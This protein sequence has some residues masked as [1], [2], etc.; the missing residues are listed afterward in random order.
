MLQVNTQ[1][2]TPVVEYPDSD[3]LPLSDNSKQFRW[4]TT[5]AGNLAGL[6]RDRA[7]VLVGG[8][9]LWYAREGDPN[10]CFAPD[11]FV[12]FGRPKGDRGSY[13]QWGRE[14]CAY[15]GGHRDPVA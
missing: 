15:D 13:K 3:G 6:Y 5:V 2:A 14:R 1:T 9:M 4:I 11:G 12:V 10:E 8:N 7:D